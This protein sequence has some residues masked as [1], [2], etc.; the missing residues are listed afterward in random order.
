MAKFARAAGFK[1]A[2]KVHKRYT[3]GPKARRINLQ[4]APNIEAFFNRQRG[5]L[6]AAISRSRRETRAWEAG[7]GTSGTA[8]PFGL[9]RQYRSAIEARLQWW[10]SAVDKSVASSSR[11][12][13][14]GAEAH[15][16]PDWTTIREDLR[17]LW[18]GLG[19]S[20]YSAID[21]HLGGQALHVLDNWP[22]KSGLSRALL[23][24]DIEPGMS[25]GELM[26]ASIVA[27]AGY[28]GYITQAGY[29]MK[30]YTT[31]SGRTR[32]KKVYED[33]KL[34]A[35]KAAFLRQDDQG[36]WV[37]DEEA[38]LADQRQKEAAGY[39][40]AKGKPYQDLMV[41]PAKGVVAAIGRDATAGAVKE[42]T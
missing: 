37:F 36:R 7:K 8:A 15:Y 18:L 11:A 5:A 26:R 3:L 13:K 19:G 20:L 40:P 25:A 16:E 39:K 1:S 12:V 32:R 33:G 31:K 10:A 21:A 9:N 34:P 29:R 30:T 38:Y 23:T 6:A 4:D 2:A 42:A 22:S 24:I 28:S 14:R 35:D 17:E 27:N 41:K